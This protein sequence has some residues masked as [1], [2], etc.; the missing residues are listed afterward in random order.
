MKASL[1]SCEAPQRNPIVIK[2]RKKLVRSSFISGLSYCNTVV[3]TNEQGLGGSFVIACEWHNNVA[4]FYL[5]NMQRLFRFSRSNVEQCCVIVVVG[6]LAISSNRAKASKL[7]KKLIIQK[8]RVRSVTWNPRT[9]TGKSR[10]LFYTRT[11]RRIN[12]AYL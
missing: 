8:K 1:V 7:Q 9:L 10:Q 4:C 5:T 2:S 3:M 11:H 6:W 12:I